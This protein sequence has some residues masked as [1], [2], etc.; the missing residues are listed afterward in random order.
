YDAHLSLVV[1]NIRAAQK[2]IRTVAEQCGGYMQSMD[3]STIIVRV[4][5]KTLDQVIMEF[6]KL[7]DVTAKEIAGHDVT[8]QMRDLTLRLKNAEELR[9]R[10]AAL[11][12][13]ATNVTEA[14]AIEKELARLTETI[15][16]L[17]GQL[18]LL[19]NK[20]AYSTVTVHLNSPVPQQAVQPLVPFAW[21]AELGGD[22]SQGDR[23]ATTSVD[24]GTGVDFVMPN[25]FAKYYEHE[26]LTRAVSADGVYLTVTRHDNVKG[27]TLG[28]WAT[29]IK[30]SLEATRGLAMRPARA[31]TL[32]NDEP[33]MWLDGVKQ[34]SGMIMGYLVAFTATE[35]HVYVFEAWGPQAS[36]AAAMPALETSFKSCTHSWWSDWLD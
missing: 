12:E 29:V 36:F 5:A 2:S 19:Q 18:Q 11:L 16:Q 20:V 33:A 24:E 32:D 21:V 7:G 34:F 26:W 4:P 3:A 6:E 1:V 14:I 9:A 23:H 10:V 31:V 30:R 27:A 13:R 28:Y 22:M 25:G 17:K 15:E 35:R 8:D